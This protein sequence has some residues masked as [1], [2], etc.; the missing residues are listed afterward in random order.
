MKIKYILNEEYFK[1][2]N[3]IRMKS[4]F[5]F[6]R[7]AESVLVIV[8][9]LMIFQDFT[10]YNTVSENTIRSV[11]FRGIIIAG[12]ILMFNYYRNRK[13]TEFVSYYKGNYPEVIIE[14]GKDINQEIDHDQYHYEWE[15]IS[16][17]EIIDSDY[18]L[19]TASSNDIVFIPH[20]EV[21]GDIREF[22]RFIRSK[23]QNCR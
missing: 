19:K 22:E 3:A 8:L 15:Q 1:R 16:E 14:L 5:L 4:R 11:I 17:F 12:L 2:L 20:E 21:P 9:I 10:F 18:I 6:Y 7:I 23:Y 13:I